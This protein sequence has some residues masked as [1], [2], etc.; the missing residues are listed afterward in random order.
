MVDKQK[1][2]P[3]LGRGLSSLIPHPPTP[4]TDPTLAAAPPSQEPPSHATPLPLGGAMDIAI[5]TVT[6]NPHQPRRDFDL[7]SLEE[8]AA[9]IRQSGIIQPIIV[10][11]A[12]DGYQLIAGERR[13]RA[14]KLA[15]LTHIPALLKDVDAAAQAQMALIEN[16]QRQDLN[17]IDR[18]EGYRQLMD[19]LGLTQ[20]ELAIRLGEERSGIANYLRLLELQESVRE[21]VR[22]SG[23]S[24]GHAKLLAG[25]PDILRQKQLADLCVKQELSVR[26]LEK[27]LAGGEHQAAPAKPAQAVAHLT[28][29]ETSLTRQL[30]MKVQVKRGQ[31]AA[32]GKLVIFYRSLDQ[33]DQLVQR[34]GLEVDVD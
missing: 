30:G 28:E 13:L 14:A 31:N 21:L 9:S 33:F 32:K 27:V 20:G 34:M 7:R 10:R 19:Q 18:A 23:L 4:A 24:M 3:R 26:N 1:Q 15:G 16:I 6:P 22:S 11:P 29:L 12:G 8:L 25:I 5:G 2:R 17:P